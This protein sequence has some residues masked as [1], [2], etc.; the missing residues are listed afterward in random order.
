MRCCSSASLWQ[1]H[2]E[3]TMLE[4]N[5]WCVALTF[6]RLRLL[7]A[8]PRAQLTARLLPRAPGS[9]AAPARDSLSELD[10]SCPVSALSCGFTL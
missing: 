3:P 2:P 9:V 4:A 7:V 6:F 10:E 8:I 1:A 5:V